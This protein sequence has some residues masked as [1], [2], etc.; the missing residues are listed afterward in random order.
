MKKITE[1]TEIR[2][3][4]VHSK[5]E[6]GNRQVHTEEYLAS[7]V[8]K[9]ASVGQRL[10]NFVIDTL[11]YYFCFFMICILFQDV[12]LIAFLLLY[13]I[14]YIILEYRF[15]F[16]FGKKVTHT[17]VIDEYGNTPSLKLI[18]LR[19]ICRMIPFDPIT[20]MPSSYSESGTGRSISEDSPYSHG[21][22]DMLSK[23]WV[24]SEIDFIELKL[25]QK[26]Q[27]EID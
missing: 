20:Y 7:R 1:L 9:S 26:E 10:I 23:T 8:I 5:D 15:K 3:R 14:Y 19:S 21:W 6:D 24:I 27:S 17:I 25:V 18:I 2:Y 22:H 12:S 4:T 11:F 13:P 16:T